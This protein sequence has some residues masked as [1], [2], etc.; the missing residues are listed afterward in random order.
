M[1]INVPITKEEYY[2]GYMKVL[3][4]FLNLSKGELNLVIAMLENDITILNTYTRGLLREILN[5]DEYSLNNIVSSLKKSRTLIKDRQG[6]MLNPQMIN[7]IDKQYISI[8]FHIVE[9]SKTSKKKE[10]LVVVDKE[11]EHQNI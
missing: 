3:N 8:T 4:S 2:K 5:K 7:N 9:N 10:A 6:L 1:E 11:N